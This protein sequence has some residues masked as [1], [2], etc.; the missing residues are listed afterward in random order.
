MMTDAAYKTEQLRTSSRIFEDQTSA[1]SNNLGRCSSIPPTSRLSYRPPSFSIK[2][3]IEGRDADQGTYRH[4]SGKGC[5]AADT[6][7]GPSRL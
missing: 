7:K 5:N 2:L 1:T 3:S 6:F 4:T